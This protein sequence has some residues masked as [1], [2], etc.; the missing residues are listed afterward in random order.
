MVVLC[1]EQQSKT[2]GEVRWFPGGDFASSYGEQSRV[3]INT[4]QNRQYARHPHCVYHRHYLR[5][6]GCHFPFLY[7]Y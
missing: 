6:T 1:T 3:L 2:D 7:G 5:G 4:G